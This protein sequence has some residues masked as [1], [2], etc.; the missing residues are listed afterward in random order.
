MPISPPTKA[1][2]R[3]TETMVSDIAITGRA[4]SAVPSMDAWRGVLPISMW[5]KMF[6]RTTIASSMMRPT[7]SESAI[8]EMM[9]SVMPRAFMAANVPSR[10]MGR[11]AMVTR[12]LRRLRKKTSTISEAAI[13]PITS[14]CIASS[15]LWRTNSD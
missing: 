13:A 6:S 14:S 10:M 7:D 4:T 12:V 3:K 11:P 9:L 5:R 8:S 1:M 15:K 2:G